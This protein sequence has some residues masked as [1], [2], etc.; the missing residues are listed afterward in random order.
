MIDLSDFHNQQALLDRL[1]TGLRKRKQEAVF[2]VGAP[3][4][5]PRNGAPGVPDVTGI[6]DLIRQEFEEPPEK[7]ELEKAL[8]ASGARRYQAAFSFLQGRRGQQT[9]NEIVCKAVFAARE[10]SVDLSELDFANLGVVEAFCRR[11]ELD[12]SGWH[13]NTGTENLGRLVARYPERFGNTLLT[14]NFDPLIEVAIRR[15]GGSHYRTTLQADGNL[16]QTEAVGCHVVHLHG[17]WHGADTLHTARQLS[18]PRPHLKD[19]LR[20]LLRNKLVV[21]CAYGGWDDIFTDALTDAVRDVTEFPEVIWTFYSGKPEPDESLITRLGP[22]IDRGRI[23]LYSGV[24]CNS[25]FQE[26][27]SRWESV[28]RPNLV[29]IT[30]QRSN[31]VSVSEEI[32]REITVRDEQGQT[33]LEGNDEDRPP[34]VDI[35]VGREVELLQLQ[36]S[37]AKVVFVTGIGGQGKSTIA[38]RHFAESQEANSYTIYVWRDCKEERE[39]FENQLASL[40][41]RLS[42]GRI[43]GED[44]A[45]QTSESIVEI[46]INEIKDKKVL[47]VFDNAD[48]YVNLE[49]ARMTGTA[50]VFVKALVEADTN[51]RAIFTCRP[52]ILYGQ[53]AVISI[54]LEGLS[55][56]PTLSL[57]ERRGATSP[58]PE[59]VEAHKLTEG[60]AFWLDLLAIQVGKQH[61]SIALQTLLA[62]ISRGGGHL[63]QSTLKSIWGTLADRERI[64]LT[65]MA[66]TVRPVTELELGDYLRDQLTFNKVTRT[67]RNLRT[68]NL[69]VVK[70]R[71]SDSDVL[72]LHP[73]V[74]VFIRN[75]FPEAERHAF[76]GG[77]IKSYHRWID[78]HRNDLLE[79]PTLVALEYW[80]QTAELDIRAGQF[81]EAF[82]VLLEVANAFQSS[83]YCR[84][85]V[86]VARMLLDAVDWVNIHQSYDRFE[87]VFKTHVFILADLGEDSEVEWLLKRYEVTVANRDARYI[88][89]CDLRCY[90]HWVRGEFEEAVSWERIGT[91]LKT[92]TTVDTQF[93]VS[94]NF[95]L[96]LRDAGRPD[97]ALPIFLAGRD[98][99]QVLNPKELKEK[100]R[101]HYYGN[102]GRCLHFM[103]QIEGALTCY[104]K[105]AI[106]LEKRSARHVINQGFVRSWV[107]E[108]LVSRNQLYLAYAFY[109]AA[110]RKWKYTSPPRAAS[111]EKVSWD[112]KKRLGGSVPIGDIEAER[113]FVDWV[114]G[115][116]LDLDSDLAVSRQS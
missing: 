51:C 21:V 64:V 61:G 72:E 28:E 31:P 65:A 75:S 77:I 74:R 43:S 13:L 98:L 15:A 81:G 111:I 71:P 83:A 116:N 96:A 70:R 41:E 2:L 26:L 62:E 42:Q 7:S 22:G 36:R 19:S 38:A 48:H 37:E 106:V 76:L 54:H 33:V 80:T 45:K 12:F 35:C 97:S 9:V 6:I 16:S 24:E 49:E 59:I 3:L 79:I 20:S 63:P 44:L 95:A 17:Y 103:G 85:F 88:N 57:F 92:S 11:L 30:D 50:E 5:A 89:Y 68:L 104:Q 112:I 101:G 14:T 4:S 107:A 46:L 93:D 78:T 99:P 109:R 86:R 114:L 66:E 39:R 53:P 10:S 84:E 52:K 94:Y 87:R 58:R 32:V 115:K 60:H 8:T 100:L 27:F 55:L 56:E 82:S 90:T 29:Q 34:L 23:T 113:I 18:Q 108:L 1:S 91:E 47:F 69:I 110:Y 105:S 73:L 40:I 25:L 102:V 67:V